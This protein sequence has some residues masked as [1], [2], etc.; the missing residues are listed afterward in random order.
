MEIKIL[1]HSNLFC[2]YLLG[3]M[4]GVTCV[5]NIARVFP[6]SLAP[7]QLACHHSAITA[8]VIR[9]LVILVSDCSVSSM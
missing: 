6:L 8:C 2:H 7:G 9:F 1:C 3:V 5:Y 4:S